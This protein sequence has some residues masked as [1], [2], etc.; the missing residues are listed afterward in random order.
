M[1]NVTVAAATRLA[2][3]LTTKQAGDEIA[4][5]FV[6]REHGWNL[7]PDTPAPD[8]V[9]VA[10]E[11]R[12]VLVFDAAAAELLAQRTLDARDTPSGSRLYLR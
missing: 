8:D 1:F 9:A 12:T 2:E 5:R 11:G 3:K 4:M 7:R 10:H 6:R